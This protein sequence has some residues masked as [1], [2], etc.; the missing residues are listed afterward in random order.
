MERADIK[1][2]VMAHY[3]RDP[4]LQNHR[5]EVTF[6]DEVGVDADGLTRE[7]FQLFGFGITEKYFHGNTMKIP[8][9]DHR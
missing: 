4:E 6:I 1:N 8:T 9:L 2:S 3:M 7:M 5:L